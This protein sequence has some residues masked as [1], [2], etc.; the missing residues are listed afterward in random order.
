MPEG[1]DIGEVKKIVEK[2]KGEYP[3]YEG[4][5]PEVVKDILDSAEEGYK[6]AG[7]GP[8]SNACIDVVDGMGRHLL[9][10]LRK[11]YK[12]A[13]VDTS[14]MF[15]PHQM[16]S[17][18]PPDWEDKDPIIADPT[19]QQFFPD[20]L[21]KLEGDG[22]AYPKVLMGTRKQLREQLQGYGLSDEEVIPWGGNP[23][24]RKRMWDY[25]KDDEY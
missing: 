22:I 24:K 15:I 8:T 19:W 1:I 16:I 12:A 9:N 6:H 17:I 13:R 14:F 7:A 10:T 21:Q 18:I 23:N 20:R 25:V 4:V 3:E 2:Q 11:G 5:P